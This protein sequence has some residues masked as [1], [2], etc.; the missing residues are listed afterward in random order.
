MKYLSK[1]WKLFGS[2][3]ALGCCAWTAGQAASLNE[4]VAVNL[5]SQSETQ[6]VTQ[7]IVKLA[8]TEAAISAMTHDTLP[9]Y[10]RGITTLEMAS[11]QRQAD[12]G[13]RVIFN[14]PSQLSLSAAKV[15]AKTLS[16][17]L[18]VEYA[19]PNA[20]Y[21]PQAGS[22]T[23]PNDPQYANQWN[24]QPLTD[25]NPAAI[26][27]PAAW[28]ITTGSDDIVIGIT[29]GGILNHSDLDGRLVGG[30][31]ATSGY[32]LVTELNRSNDGDGR[33]MDPTDPGDWRVEGDLCSPRRSLWHGTMV[34][35][36][37]G[38]ETNNGEGIASVDWNAKV[39][40]AR[41]TGKCG[42][43]IADISDGIR[44][45]SGEPVDGVV[46]ANPAD[47]INMSIGATGDCWASAQEAIDAAV[48]R[49]TVVVVA[50]GNNNGDVANFSPAN[51]QNVIAVA[52]LEQTGAR[53]SISNTGEEADIAAPGIN[54]WATW[55]FGETTS[56]DGNDYVPGGGTSSA[57]PQVSGVVALMLAS[58]PLLKSQGARLP[59]LIEAKL[60]ASARPFVTG[61][62]DDC[63]VGHCGAGML[64]AGQAVLA[65]S[66]APTVEAGVNQNVYGGIQ[67]TL[68]AQTTDDAYS[69]L[70][71]MRY[72]WEQTA[73]TAVSLLNP[74]AA[75]VHF[76][77][78]NVDDTLTFSVIATDDTG[79]TATDTVSIQVSNVDIEPDAFTFSDK[80]GVQRLVVV[81]S[82][83][84]MVNGID[85]SVP[86]SI[87]NGE[88][89]VNGGTFMT[90][91]GI[92]NN[93]NTIKLRHTSSND[94]STTVRT[95]LTIGGV[96]GTFSSTTL[97]KRVT[98]GG[99]GS[100]GLW[101]LLFSCM[102]LVV[103]VIKQRRL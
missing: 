64:D 27:A 34:A 61:T 83:S 79:L 92:V 50:A 31:A 2:V 19:E 60:K 37:F 46:N 25:D 42:G 101:A 21:Y 82:D 48:A 9:G 3:F 93:G 13:I 102:L 15:Q 18:R 32:D 103:G 44:W 58:N 29:D 28:A 5:Q 59:A 7:L 65:V 22:T 70:A 73:G 8:P 38:A 36:S 63:A 12:G 84:I 16:D 68:A 97:A 62:D 39:S 99:G 26:N 88:Y 10:V 23:P 43:N 49:G 24:L 6:Q 89:S 75:T 78:P 54:V 67:A 80:T 17:D 74:N 90:T 41:V 95:T 69:E 98:S 81:E 71:K 40:M 85:A 100:F 47:V 35:G 87:V 51:C 57:T 72:R 52:G 76:D 91:G 4:M 77:T 45:L 56:N 30:S 53:L 55:E 96:S 66:T 33:D 1:K 94:F 86:V 20:A 11:A 14:L